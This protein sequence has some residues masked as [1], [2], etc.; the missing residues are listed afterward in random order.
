MSR[1]QSCVAE[2]ELSIGNTNIEQHSYVILIGYDLIN[3]VDSS[4]CHPQPSDSSH[5]NTNS[6]VWDLPV[7]I[8]VYQVFTFSNANCLLWI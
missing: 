3:V 6:V 1:A 4:Q 2:D 7:Y 5:R 8:L